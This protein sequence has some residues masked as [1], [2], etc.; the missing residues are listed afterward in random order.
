MSMDRTCLERRTK[1][2]QPD[3]FFG[4]YWADLTVVRAE[5]IAL[6]TQNFRLQ[7]NRGVLARQRRLG[8]FVGI[9]NGVCRPHTQTQ[10]CSSKHKL[11]IVLYYTAK[12]V[13]LHNSYR[14][15]G[16][17][18]FMRKHVGVQC[19]ICHMAINPHAS[20]LETHPCTITVSE[21]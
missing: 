14:L 20:S 9:A 16:I 19:R 4:L 12:G 6:P 3:S 11:C 17:K 1:V 7:S 15:S 21:F 8:Y 13:D 10:G 18:R 2:A 5:R